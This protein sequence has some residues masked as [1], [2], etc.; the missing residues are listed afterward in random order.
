[1]VYNIK[2]WYWDFNGAVYSSKHGKFIDDEIAQEFVD[3]M[4]AGNSPI[5]ADSLESVIPLFR[6]NDVPPYH[7]V[8]KST[9]IFRLNDDQLAAASAALNSNLRLRERWYA[10]D[11]GYINADD[12]DSIALLE[13]IGVDPKVILAPEEDNV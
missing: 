6:E 4:G 5:T 11:Q 3:W 13:A 7:R 2:D 1:M 12:P 9:V 10:P 8:R